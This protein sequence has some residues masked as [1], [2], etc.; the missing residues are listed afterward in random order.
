MTMR[1]Q[2]ACLAA[3]LTGAIA[4]R[5]VPLSNTKVDAYNVR[6][7]TETFSGLYKFTTNTLLVETADAITNMGS[8]TIKFY[9]G[10]DTFAQSGVILPPTVTNLMTLARDEPSYHHVLDMPFRH[11]IIWEYPFANP[12]EWWASGYNTTQ[13]AKDY[14]EMYALTCYLLTN[15]NNSG[16]TFYLGHWEGDGYLS[17]TVN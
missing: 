14:A 15:Y 13:G 3:F 2:N 10:S 6:I 17:V 8:D 12:D 16:K 7:G 9:M 5:G 4:L 11:F 1:I